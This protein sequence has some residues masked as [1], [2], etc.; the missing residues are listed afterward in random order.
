MPRSTMK[1]NIIN[2]QSFSVF[3]DISIYVREVAKLVFS[4]THSSSFMCGICMWKYFYIVSFYYISL[5][6][7]QKNQFCINLEC[8]FQKQ[9]QDNGYIHTS[10]IQMPKFGTNYLLNIKLYPYHNIVIFVSI[11]Q[12]KGYRNNMKHISNGRAKKLFM[13][14]AL[15]MKIS[16]I[17]LCR[18]RRHVS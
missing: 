1:W 2:M 14:D 13:K 16:F 12:Q 5:H 8:L 7:V 9:P 4:P 11:Y 17:K 3:S 18:F 15:H 10:N 6:K